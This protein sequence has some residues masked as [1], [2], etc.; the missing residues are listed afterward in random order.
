VKIKNGKNNLFSFLT[1]EKLEEL[2]NKAHNYN[3]LAALAGSLDT[4]NIPRVY[5]L[6]AD[7]IGVRGAVCTKKDRLAGKLE[8]E[9]VIEFAEEISKL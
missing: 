9:K 7:I 6:G 8:R 2:V 5:N 3:L 4:Q 1:D